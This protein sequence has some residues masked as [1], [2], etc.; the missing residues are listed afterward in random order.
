[1]T[2]ETEQAVPTSVLVGFTIRGVRDQHVHLADDLKELRLLAISMG[3]E[4]V[5]EVFQRNMNPESGTLI[6]THLLGLAKTEV[7]RTGATLLC[8]DHTLSGSQRA[9]IEDEVGCEVLDRTEVI[10]QIFARR[11]NTAEGM[12]QVELAQLT[13]LLPRLRGR[14]GKELSA[15][16]GGIGTRGP[17]ETKLETDRRVI[18]KR[19]AHLKGRIEQIGKR[20]RIQRKKRQQAGVPVIALVGY[21]N[22]GKS[23]LLNALAG[24]GRPKAYTDDRLFATLDPL[25]RKAFCPPLGREVL[26]TDTVGFIDRLP[27]ELVAAFRATLE[28]VLFAD[29]LGIIVDGSEPDWERKLEIVERTLG[30]IGAGE[31]PRILVF[32]KADLYPPREELDEAISIGGA[33]VMNGVRLSA[34]TG[35]GLEDFWESIA[36][37]VVA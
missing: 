20:R 17:G 26:L 37:R 35:A 16:G 24:G 9:N 4:V 11:A 33:P 5:G 2:Y 22:A 3:A 1:M 23:T 8:V 28:E 34:L 19:I 32:S 7:Q 14:G 27:T 15:L 13:Y 10:L 25:T 12:L 30:D 31:I 29:L 36:E 21:T 6:S 18:G